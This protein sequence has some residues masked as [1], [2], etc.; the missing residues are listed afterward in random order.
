MK[1]ISA[2]MKKAMDQWG[3]WKDAQ[4]EYRRVVAMW[5][6]NDVAWYWLGR[7]YDEPGMFAEA[8][9]AYG[10]A[11]ALAPT[12]AVYAYLYGRAIWLRDYYVVRYAEAKRQGIHEEYL[13]LSGE[14]AKLDLDRPM[15]MLEYAITLAPDQWRAHEGD[16]AR[17]EGLLSLLGTRTSLPR[18][19]LRG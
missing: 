17:P 5:D 16:R 19:G 12:N 18:V 4:A 11:F 3:N 2:A 14:E 8:T 13:V 7:T 6:G 10:K 1:S 15:Q 9:E